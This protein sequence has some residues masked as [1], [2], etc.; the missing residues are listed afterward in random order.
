MGIPPASYYPATRVL[1]KLSP[2]DYKQVQDPVE[3]I[4]SIMDEMYDNCITKERLVL[5][6]MQFYTWKR[7]LQPAYMQQLYL[8]THN[9]CIVY[10]MHVVYTLCMDGILGIFLLH[11]QSL[12]A[13]SRSQ[14]HVG[15]I[16]SHYFKRYSN[17]LN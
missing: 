14:Q 1:T 9:A 4:S 12:N 11:S 17:N 15:L 5:H 7:Q 13:V 2:L 6:T 3:I 10:I 16:H 8:R